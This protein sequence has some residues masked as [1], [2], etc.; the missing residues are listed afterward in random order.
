[1]ADQFVLAR[2]ERITGVDLQLFEF[3]YDLTW[4]AFFLNAEEKVYGRYGGRDAKSTDARLSLVG[5]RFALESALEKHKK[6][7]KAK[8][9]DRPEKPLLAEQYAAAKKLGARECIHCHQVY[10]F[11]R[12]DAKQAGSFKREDLWVYPLPENVG[13]V[14]DNDQGNTVRTVTADSAA[15]KAGLRA[16]DVLQTLNGF[17]VASSGDVQHALHRGPP[18]G[19]LPLAWQRDGKPMTA[20]LQLAEGWRKTNWTWRPSMLDILPS[21]SLFGDD[22]TDKEKKALGLGEKRLAF[23]QDKT[24]GADAKKA[25]VQAGDVI[26]GIDDQT[27]EMTMLEFLAYIRRNHLVGDKITLNLIRDGK[28]VNLPIQL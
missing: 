23:R 10:E 21:L 26:V 7:P 24:V 12:F 18:K 27:M 22:L 8:R 1:V 4:M 3:D 14:L 28:R 11:R 16:G 15:A 17:S 5:L 19:E 6:D 9:E 13:L 25:G 2:L 20:K